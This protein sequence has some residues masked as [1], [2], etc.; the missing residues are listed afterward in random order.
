MTT[1]WW[2]MYGSSQADA[3]ERR[4][5]DCKQSCRVDAMSPDGVRC[6]DCWRARSQMDSKRRP[7]GSRPSRGGAARK[8]PR[9]ARV[10]A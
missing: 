3:D 2:D 7:N 1:D 8:S 6:V 9:P 4:C 5:W 10:R